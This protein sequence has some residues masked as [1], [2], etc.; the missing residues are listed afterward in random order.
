MKR[1]HKGGTWKYAC[2]C[3]SGVRYEGESEAWAQLKTVIEG[4][5]A[6]TTAGIEEND[7]FA[8][9][10]AVPV[11]PEDR[12]PGKLRGAGARSPL[13]WKLMLVAMALI[14]GYSFLTMKTVLDTVPTFMLL[15]C[16]FLLSAVIMFIIFRKRIK[17]HFNR[18]YL[19][20]GVLMGCVIWSAYAAQTLGLV[21]TTP[22][23]NAFLTGT[24]CILVPFIALILFKERVTKWH[25]ASALLCLVGVGFVALDNFSIQMGDLMTLVGAVSFAVDMAVVGHIGRTRDVSVLTSWMFLF[26]GLFSLAATTAF[27]PRVPAGQWTPEI[28]GQLVFLAVVCTTIGLLLQNQALSHMPPATG[29]LLLSLESPSGVLFSVLMAGEVLTGKLIFGF[30]L[31]FLSIVLSETHFNFLRKWFPKK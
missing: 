19:G 5:V 25:I 24:Y 13:F 7:P 11:P 14:W 20:F 9:K 27:E 8:S 12:A 26:V 15:A 1:A 16:R 29:S 3:R 28:V 22:G 2:A 23:K 21:D 10:D 31:I 4:Q 30:V 18:E 6:K 17:A